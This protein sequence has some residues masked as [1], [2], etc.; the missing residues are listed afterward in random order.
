MPSPILCRTTLVICSQYDITL[1]VGH[2]PGQTLL[3]SADALSRWHLGHPFQD[4]VTH[5]VNYH[6]ITLINVPVSVFQLSHNL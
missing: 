5:I 2:V 3:A 6:T 1:G 4:R